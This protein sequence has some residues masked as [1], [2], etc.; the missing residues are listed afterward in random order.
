MTAVSN[1]S[2]IIALSRIERLHL[3]PNLFGHI[4]VPEAVWLEVVVH[5]EGRPGS[6][7]CI[8]AEKEGWLS[9]GQVKDIWTVEVLEAHLGPGESEAIFWHGKSKP[10]GCLWT[11]IWLGLTRYAWASPLRVQ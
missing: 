8:Q 2:P 10:S 4:I 1:A 11:T 6:K 5:G 3:L 7:E 9:R